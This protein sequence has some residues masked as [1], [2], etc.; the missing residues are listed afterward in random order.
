MDALDGLFDASYVRH[1]MP[2]QPLDAL[3]Q[4]RRR[5]RAPGA[6]SAHVEED[7]AIAEAAESDV[8]AVLGDGRP[9]T[10][11]DQF[12][13]GRDRLGILGGKEFFALARRGRSAD[14]HRRAG[15]EVL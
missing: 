15:N 12:L 9:N 1:E 8:A 2:E 3:L 5:R 11:L 4:R 14:E 10:R 6:R 7:H 13:D